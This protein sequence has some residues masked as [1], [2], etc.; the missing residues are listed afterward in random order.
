M[1]LPFLGLAH[2][3]E[4]WSL[5]LA[6]LAV[7]L[8]VIAFG[9]TLWRRFASWRGL[10]VA[11]LAIVVTTGLSAAGT[12]ALWKAA[13]DL[14][15]WEIHRWSEWPEVIPPYGWQILI[16]AN[17]VVAVLTVVIYRL[18]RR[19][20]ERA[21]F[22]LVVLSIFLLLAVALAI[23]TPQATIAPTWPV[24]VGSASWIVVAVVRRDGKGWP[25]D[26]GALLSA[27]P[28]VTFI[29]PLVPGVFMGDG[30]KSVAITAGVWAIL[31]GII[32]PA[33]DGLFVRRPAEK[34]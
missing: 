20:S 24:L 26:A 6:I 8:L 27:I 5:P 33:V 1:Y 34:S 17:L 13:P 32:L 10:G 3:P 9:L 14:F 16:L 29:L 15:G 19:W 30:T 11:V 25:V 31:L 12:N 28:A 22:S 4:A 2:Y 21:N 7:I 18:A 23:S